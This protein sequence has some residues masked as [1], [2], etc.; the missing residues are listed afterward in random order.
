MVRV[1]RFGGKLKYSLFFKRYLP[2]VGC[3]L[4]LFRSIFGVQGSNVLGRVIVALYGRA[5][6]V[7]GV[8]RSVVC[9][10]YEGR[11]GLYFGAFFGGIIR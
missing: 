9:E 2:L 6:L 4:Y 1:R 5:G 3:R 8:V 10:H 7:F 11:R